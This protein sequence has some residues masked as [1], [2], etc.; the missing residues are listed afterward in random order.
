MLLRLG[1]LLQMPYEGSY[2]DELPRKEDGLRS[3]LGRHDA[4]GFMK[5]ET[6]DLSVEMRLLHH[7]VSRIFFPREEDIT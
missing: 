3:I 6:K 2:L 5:L 7:M 4:A 1:R